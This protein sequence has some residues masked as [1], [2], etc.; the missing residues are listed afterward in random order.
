MIGCVRSLAG[1]AQWQ[2]AQEAQLPVQPPAGGLTV[3]GSPPF[4]AVLMIAS[5]WL[6]SA[7]HSALAVLY[8]GG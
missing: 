2:P 1:R 3:I 5:M 7:S 4:M 6:I 8:V